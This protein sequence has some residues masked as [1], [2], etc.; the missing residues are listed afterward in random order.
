MSEVAVQLAAH[1]LP[2]E[3]A[4]AAQ[5]LSADLRARQLHAV[6]QRVHLGAAHVNGVDE[7]VREDRVDVLGTGDV[8]LAEVD[9]GL[10]RQLRFARRL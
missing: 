6:V 1:R 8:L 9:L 5:V 10:Q 7:L 3:V 2:P 4:L